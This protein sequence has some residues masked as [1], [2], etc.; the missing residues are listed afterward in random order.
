MLATY[1]PLA[2]THGNARQINVLAL[3]VDDLIHGHSGEDHL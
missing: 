2:V 3:A 1:S